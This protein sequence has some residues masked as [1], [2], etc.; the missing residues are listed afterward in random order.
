MGRWPACRGVGGVSGDAS[1]AETRQEAV[2]LPLV[3]IGDREAAQVE[4]ILTGREREEEKDLWEEVTCEGGPLEGS[5]CATVS[6]V[7]EAGCQCVACA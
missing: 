7:D 1:A 2:E 4:R 3:L 5:L 6:R